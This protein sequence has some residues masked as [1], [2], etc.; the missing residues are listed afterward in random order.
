MIVVTCRASVR[1]ARKT[2]RNL[3]KFEAVRA[4]RYQGLA[5]KEVRT[6]GRWP[7]IEDLAAEQL[8]KI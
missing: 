7:D 4:I 6:P 2:G 3:K 1:R 8:G 5:L